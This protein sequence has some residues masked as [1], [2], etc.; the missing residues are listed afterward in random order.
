MTGPTVAE[1][2]LVDVHAHFT[3]PHDLEPTKGAGHVDTDG[4][5]KAYWPDPGRVTRDQ[6]R[7]PRRT[8]R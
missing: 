7:A 1:G 5:P 8:S 4:M 2:S 6:H 3:T